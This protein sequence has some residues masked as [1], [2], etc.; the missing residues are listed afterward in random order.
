MPEPYAHGITKNPFNGKTYDAAHWNPS[1]AF[2]AGQLVSTLQ[3]LRVWAKACATGAQISPG[4]QK[5]RLTWV[6]FPPLTPNRTYG[7]GIVYN[8]GWLGHEGSI[9]G[10]NTM[11][12]YLPRDDATMIMLVNSDIGVKDTSPASALFRALSTIVTPTNALTI[13]APSD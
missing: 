10:Y 1:W 2:A 13:E 7:L 11:S 8:D 3:D 4:L 9:P 6:K 12:Y 5:Q